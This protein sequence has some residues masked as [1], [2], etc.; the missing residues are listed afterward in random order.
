ML[1]EWFTTLDWVL[2]EVYNSQL[3]FEDQKNKYPG[4]EEFEYLHT[5]A[6]G[7]WKKVEDYYKKVDDNAA[8]YAAQAF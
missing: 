1:A 3:E 8:Y 7:A 4:C 6:H 5:A 2:Q